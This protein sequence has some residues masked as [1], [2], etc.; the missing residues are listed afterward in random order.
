MFNPKKEWFENLMNVLG[1]KDPNM[2]IS[3]VEGKLKQIA[4]LQED[5]KNKS[6]VIIDLTNKVSRRNLQ[7]ADLK[8]RVAELEAYNMTFGDRRDV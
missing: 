6:A 2:I 3:N 4:E 1:E 7:I 8:K 5:I